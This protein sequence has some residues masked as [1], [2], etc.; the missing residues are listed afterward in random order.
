MAYLFVFWFV[1]GFAAA[2]IRQFKGGSAAAGAAL[3]FLLG[4]VG[5]LIAI[6]TKPPVVCPFCRSPVDAGA[7]TCPRCQSDLRSAAARAPAPE[8]VERADPG[9]EKPSRAEPPSETPR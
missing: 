4:P 3:G 5:V 1:C 6:L 2:L 7:G 8:L 9:Q